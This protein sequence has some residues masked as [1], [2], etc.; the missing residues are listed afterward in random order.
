MSFSSAVKR[1]VSLAESSDLGIPVIEGIRTEGLPTPCINVFIEN[2]TEFSPSLTDVYRINI[3]VRYEEHYADST[4]EEVNQNFKKLLDVFVV[5][6]LSQK[7]S[8]DGIHIFLGSVSDIAQDVQNDL[9]INHFNI[10]MIME[11]NS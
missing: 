8:T 2:A 1:I 4:G 9:F 5:D 6:D 7:L 3:N 10:S 11:R